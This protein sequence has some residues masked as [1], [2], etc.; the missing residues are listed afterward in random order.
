MF[1]QMSVAFQQ[2]CRI[3]MMTVPHNCNAMS[4]LVGQP[5]SCASKPQSSNEYIAQPARTTLESRFTGYI[6]SIPKRML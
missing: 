3:Q 1:E 6:K 2:M 5:V 4:E